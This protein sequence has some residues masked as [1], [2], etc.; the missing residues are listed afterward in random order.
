MGM[1]DGMDGAL[2]VL[3]LPLPWAEPLS[4]ALDSHWRHPLKP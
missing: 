3:R 1:V 4:F 2:G